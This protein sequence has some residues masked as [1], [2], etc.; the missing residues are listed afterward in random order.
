MRPI[1]TRDAEVNPIAAIRRYPIVV[2]LFAVAFGVL[3]AVFATGRPE[4]FSA[5]AG[6]VVEDARTSTVFNS[7]SVDAERYVADQVA[8]LE[9]RVVAELASD[10]ASSVDPPFDLSVDDFLSNT[11]ISSSGDSNFISISFV[12]SSALRAQSGAD[13]IGHAYEQVIQAALAEDAETA[14]ADLDEAI[15]A[16][17]GEIEAIQTEIEARRT[18]NDERVELDHQLAEIV[19]GLVALRDDSTA[20]QEELDATSDVGLTEEELAA[21]ALVLAAID[22]VGGQIRQLTEELR[23]RLLVSDVEARVPETAFLLR[24]QEDAAAR[25]SELTLRR[26]QIEVDARLAGNGVAFLAPAG[27]GISR[28]VP[29]SST[30]VIMAAVG[31]LI[32]A[33]F[34]YWLFQRRRDL[35]DRLAPQAVLGVPLLAE[36]PQL[37]DRHATLGSRQGVAGVRRSVS[38]AAMLPVLNAPTSPQAEAFRLLVGALNRRLEVARIEGVADGAPVAARGMVVAVCSSVIGEGKTAVATNT[39]IAAT[40]AG[41]RVVLVDADFG[42]Q[43]ATRLVSQL[44]P[45]EG[46]IGLTEVVQDG[47]L[48]DDAVVGIDVGGGLEFGLLRRGYG[49]IAAPDLFGSQT[50]GRVLDELAQQNDLVIVDLPPLLHVAYATAA[51]QKADHALVVVRHGSAIDDLRELRYRLEVIGVEA[52]GYVYTEAPRRRGTVRPIGPSGD[53]LGNAS[54]RSG[55][56]A[57]DALIVT[58]PVD[59]GVAACVHQL[60]AAAVA[61]GYRTTVASPAQ[62]DESFAQ[63]TTGLGAHH[64]TFLNHKRG[65]RLRDLGNVLRLRRLMRDRDVVHL[66]S[67]KAGAVGRLS[68]VLLGRKRPGVVFTPHA[69]SWLVGGRAAGVYRAIERILAPACDVIVCVSDSE[70]TEGRETLGRAADR[71]TVIENGVDLHRFTPTGPRAV[72]DET[73]P[74][75]VCVGRLSRQKGQDV[76]LHAVAAL[77]NRDARIRFVGSGE[78]ASD[79]A[80]L[81]KELQIEDRVEWEGAVDDT[82]AQYRVADIVVAPSRWEGLSLVML[83]AMASGAA[84]VASAVQGTEAVGDAGLLVPA[85]DHKALAEALDSLLGDDSRRR[86]LGKKARQRARNYD[87]K[88]SSASNLEVWDRLNRGAR[89][90]AGRTG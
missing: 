36:L 17:V 85:E 33:G 49:D 89:H 16:A 29:T 40:Q 54:T 6:I 37:S 56:P 4:A 50:A 21:R 86:A 51:I 9:S 25:L 68:A 31:A 82:A 70:A 22:D 41:L 76:A 64:V 81:A 72:R 24:Q 75:I 3:G 18:D 73:A 23:G 57:L 61:A 78:A 48:L 45:A 67:S 12:A 71:I 42:A 14:V 2:L 60:A 34:A 11:T 30:A 53:V 39:A 87:A 7:R 15:A 80:A 20:L 58:Q 28:G 84:L 19:A 79:L 52:L 35:E 26:S 83:E 66:H 13:A 8:I 10:I 63:T 62:P 32:G 69:W 44:P 59:G 5:R 46:P 77:Q 47:L 38:D 43:D 27:P 55:G 1:E 65:P 90:R 74:L 88:V